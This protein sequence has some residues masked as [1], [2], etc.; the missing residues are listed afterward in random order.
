M[1]AAPATVVLGRGGL[2]REPL[3]AR[4][5]DR[6]AQLGI[7]PL[8]ACPLAA[9]FVILTG[10]M[11]EWRYNAS[12]NASAMTLSQVM[13]LSWLGL[14]PLLI[15]DAVRL[16]ARFLR[17]EILFSSEETAA[18][19]FASFLRRW[20]AGLLWFSIP[21]AMLV[22]SVVIQGM[23]GAA[24]T[25][26]R[27]WAVISYGSVFLLSGVGFW[28][29]IALM[30]LIK[31]LSVADLVYRPYHPDHFGGMAAV[32]SFAVRGALYFSSGALA[33]PLAFELIGASQSGSRLSSLAYIATAIFIGFVCAAFVIPI[34]DIKERADAERVRVA[35]EARSRLQMLTE[36]YRGLPT[37]DEKVARQ[38]EMCFYMECAELEK[39]RE[40]PY[41][42]RVLAQFSIAVAVPIA[43]V[44]L[45]ALLG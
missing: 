38:V 26:L 12:Y 9:L 36:A 33:L 31:D 2:A 16:A 11:L 41:D 10:L 28:G 19:L 21:W 29:V 6:L 14:G 39:L 13:T 24:P 42:L 30:R 23:Y 32:G 43:A 7:P 3:V 4:S 18:D 17:S 15:R 37:H 1:S 20:R 34:S 22:T 27:V 44:L 45:E 40:Y 8:V 5:L 35:L 25:A